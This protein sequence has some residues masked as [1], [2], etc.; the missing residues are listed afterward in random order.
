M[1]RYYTG[2]VVTRE[3]P[4]NL[5]SQQ[6]SIIYGESFAGGP[7]QYVFEWRKCRPH[8]DGSVPTDFDGEYTAKFE[9]TV[10]L[11][12]FTIGHQGDT[13]ANMV[14][15]YYAVRYRAADTN[16]PAYAAMGYAWSEWTDP[17]ALAEGWVQRVLNNVT[18]FA[19]RM[20]DLAENEAE[21]PVSMI[22]QAGR[23]YEGDI[24]IR[25]GDP[26]RADDVHFHRRGRQRMAR[27]EQRL[28]GDG[29]RRDDGRRL[30]RRRHRCAQAGTRLCRGGIPV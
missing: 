8:A 6:L 14:N 7:E 25:I 24:D 13:L 1:P 18:P 30:A 23:P 10:G 19:Q 20:R 3:D 4:L 5:L 26:Q 16:S 22:R 12:R 28:R 9:P 17:P 29:H 27:D 11:T 2:R 21:T 15:T